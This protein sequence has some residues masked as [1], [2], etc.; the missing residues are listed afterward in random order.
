MSQSIS[1]TGMGLW[2][3]SKEMLEAANI[4]I[5]KGISVMGPM[6]YLLGHSLEVGIKSFILSKGANQKC[7]RDIGHDLIKAVE[8]SKPC[9]IESYFTFS[10][11]Q[12]EMIMLL[13]KYY[14]TKEFEYR[15][16]GNKTFP[17]AVEFASMIKSLL[18]AIKPVCRASV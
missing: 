13:N 5:P 6:Y 1:H 10:N 8:W 11:E 15:K 4:L 18:E 7:L 12:V 3:D 2:T 17:D 14:K 16:T 9:G